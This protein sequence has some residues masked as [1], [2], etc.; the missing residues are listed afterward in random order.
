MGQTINR[1]LSHVVPMAFGT[2]FVIGEFACPAVSCPNLVPLSQ[3][4]WDRPPLSHTLWDKNSP[5]WSQVHE[6]RLAAA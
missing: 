2:V 3:P 6:P 1:A 5:S 4:P